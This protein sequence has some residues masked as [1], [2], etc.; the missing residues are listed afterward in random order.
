[1]S[2]QGGNIRIASTKG[3]Q[4]AQRHAEPSLSFAILIVSAVSRSRSGM[5]GQ[6]MHLCV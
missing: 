3:D 2:E 4:T 6:P 5:C 1:M